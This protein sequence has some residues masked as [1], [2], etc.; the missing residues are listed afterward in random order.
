MLLDFFC[1][2]YYSF[3]YFYIHS[4]PYSVTKKIPFLFSTRKQ[5]PLNHFL[6]IQN[7]SSAFE[8]SP[9][10]TVTNIFRMSFVLQQPT[11]SIRANVRQRLLNFSWH[12][13]N[14]KAIILFCV[15][16]SSTCNLCLSVYVVNNQNNL[17]QGAAHRSLT[18]CPTNLKRSMTRRQPLGLQP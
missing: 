6:A 15:S 18:D 12:S 17:I 11:Q 10:A 16:A 9:I 8:V 4:Y 2:L 3:I 13:L 1:F 14:K 5:Q 7:Y